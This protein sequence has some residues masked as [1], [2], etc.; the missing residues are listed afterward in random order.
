VADAAH[1]GRLLR[2]RARR[3][4]PRRRRARSRDERVGL[5]RALADRRGGGRSLH[6]L[7]R[8]AHDP[9]R[10]RGGDERRAAR[11]GAGDT[12]EVI[13]R[14]GDTLPPRIPNEGWTPGWRVGKVSA[15]VPL[16]MG[17]TFLE[18]EVANLARPDVTERLEF[19]IDS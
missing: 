15:I 8:R 17:L 3:H 14:A 18:L 9:R 19:L 5:R 1:L 11:R 16:A 10:R 2:V 7:A 13:S 4:R 12:P 6:E